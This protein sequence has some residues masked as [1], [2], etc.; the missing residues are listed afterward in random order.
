MALGKQAKTI[1][2]K[3][4]RAVLAE[5]DTRRYPVRDRVMF[6]LSLRAGLPAKEVASVTWGMV[7]DAEGQ[8]AEVIALQNRASKGRAEAASFPCTV[9]SKPR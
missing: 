3:Q 8:V 6:L 5:L 1:S 2:D 9:T 7:T 4:I